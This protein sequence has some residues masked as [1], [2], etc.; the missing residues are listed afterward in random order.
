M[1]SPLMI[2]LTLNFPAV[3]GELD[4]FLFIMCS[5]A[6]TLSFLLNLMSFNDVTLFPSSL[7]SGVHHWDALVS[8]PM[9]SVAASVLLCQ[10]TDFSQ[11]LDYFPSTKIVHVP[12]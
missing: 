4:R 1:V 2:L 7:M 11:F 8:V 10:K 5:R 6:L 12:F 9:T 3:H